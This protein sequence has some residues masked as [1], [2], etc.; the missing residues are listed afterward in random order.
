MLIFDSI[1]H[2][3]GYDDDCVP[4]HAISVKLHLRHKRTSVRQSVRSF[5]SLSVVSVSGD[6]PMKIFIHQNTR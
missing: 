3:R 5:V 4:E 1:E 6:H 2:C